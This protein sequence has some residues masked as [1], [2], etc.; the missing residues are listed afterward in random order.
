MSDALCG[1][2]FSLSDA[3][4]GRGFSM[5]DAVCGRGFSMS[6]ASCGRGFS[7]SVVAQFQKNYPEIYSHRF[8]ESGD[9]VESARPRAKQPLL[10]RP[11]ER[12]RM[13]RL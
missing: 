4:C 2:G 1:R 9:E 8:P 12:L 10:R 13:M 6:D 5:S 11:L 7:T 3:L